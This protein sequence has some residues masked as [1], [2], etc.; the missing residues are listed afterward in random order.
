MC[1]L[2]VDEEK[3]FGERV[4]KS[5]KRIPYSDYGTDEMKPFFGVLS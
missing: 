3:D 5:E 4:C 1:D 2:S